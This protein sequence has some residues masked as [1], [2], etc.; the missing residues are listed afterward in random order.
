MFTSSCMRDLCHLKS[1][2]S[3]TPG[4]L[5]SQPHFFKWL[6]FGLWATSQ[7][8]NKPIAFKLRFVGNQ[9]LSLLYTLWLT[10]P[11]SP[12]T[13]PYV[14]QLVA[15]T[16]SPF[17]SILGIFHSYQLNLYASHTT[18]KPFHMQLPI[19]IA[20]FSFAY[21]SSEVFIVMNTLY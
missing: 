18:S 15:P 20:V 13:K 8:G 2:R 17:G 3:G 9:A 5:S 7:L 1:C 4:V 19:H 6:R 11:I 14:S 12:S 16:T 21:R 10:I